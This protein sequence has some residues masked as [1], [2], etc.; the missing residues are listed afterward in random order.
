MFKF[1]KEGHIPEEK[2]R[3]QMDEIFVANGIIMPKEVLQMTCNLTNAFVD[4]LR[5]GLF[6][7]ECKR[8]LYEAADKK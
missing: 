1:N 2:L 4:F 3:K 7:D 6:C 8:K 5:K